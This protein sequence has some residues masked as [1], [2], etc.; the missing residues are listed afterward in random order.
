MASVQMNV[1]MDAEL[2][3]AG[4]EA[5]ASIGL[6]PSE[7]VR[8]V[9]RQAAA[10]QEGLQQLKQMAEE[11]GSDRASDK[12]AEGFREGWALVDR[13]VKEHGLDKVP[14]PDMTDR[15]LLEE[16]LVDRMKERGLEW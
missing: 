9:W 14:L 2:K 4:D 5:L 7:A 6:T 13:F 16:A 8:M 12:R 3:K 11:P 15:E 10:R 1:R